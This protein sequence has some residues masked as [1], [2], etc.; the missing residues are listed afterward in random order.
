MTYPTVDRQFVA[1]PVKDLPDTL[2]LFF[3]AEKSSLPTLSG[4]EGAKN[5]NKIQW[6]SGLGTNRKATRVMKVEPYGTTKVR[7]F[8]RVTKAIVPQL[9]AADKSNARHAGCLKLATSN[10]ELY[11]SK[12]VKLVNFPLDR[13]VYQKFPM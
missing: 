9:K 2:V 13:C 5:W 10:V 6:G 1:R 7:V 8:L 3:T 12:E 4:Q 11:V